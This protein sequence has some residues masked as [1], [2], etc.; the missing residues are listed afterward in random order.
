MKLIFSELRIL[1]IH[2][3]IDRAGQDSLYRRLMVLMRLCILAMLFSCI[4]GVVMYMFFNSFDFENPPNVFINL[5]HQKALSLQLAI[6]CLYAPIA[7]ELEFRVLLRY[8]KFNFT[9]FLGIWSYLL[10]RQVTAGSTLLG[11]HSDISMS[12]AIAIGV[13]VLLYS[14]LD[15]HKRLNGYLERFWLKWYRP[16][17]Y[18]SVI[19]FGFMH[20]SNFDIRLSTLLLTPILTLPQISLGFLLGYIRL[21]YGVGYSML[22]HGGY[23]FF[24]LLVW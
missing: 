18:F 7:E 5:F 13:G 17:F 21:K 15:K 12:I 24:I 14:L 9:M 2:G 23:N 19:S 1:L 4:A 3:I 10:V 22:L 6:A 20:I 8:S 16:V 11:E